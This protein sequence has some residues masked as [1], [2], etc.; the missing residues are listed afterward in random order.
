MTVESETVYQ[1]LL[2]IFR[3][4]LPSIRVCYDYLE[5]KMEILTFA[6]GSCVGRVLE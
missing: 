4:K 1:C 2:V 5:Y 6:C 3:V